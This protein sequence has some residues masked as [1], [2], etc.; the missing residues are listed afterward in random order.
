MSLQLI[1]TQDGSHTLYIPEMD[2]KYHASEGA[3]FE[4]QKIYIENGLNYVQRKS[5][6]VFEFGF[7]TGLNALL[8]AQYA[9]MYHVNTVYHSIELY[10]VSQDIYT[11][12]NYGQILGDETSYRHINSSPWDTPVQIN[13]YF[14]LTKIHGDITTYTLRSGLYDVIFFAGFGPRKQPEV[15][16]KSV[17]ARMYEG[18][19]SRGVLV[20]YCAQGQ[21]KRDLK[22]IGF[23]VENIP[24]P[25][26]KYETT[27][28]VKL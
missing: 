17:L 21:F 23:F 5:V 25:N 9:S 4:C 16:H 8:A 11:Q 20:T 28:A 2:E 14:T 12:L 15:W 3:I 10:P 1:T 13:P 19:C 24:I 7:G 18:L 6:A 27:R 26:G 22:E